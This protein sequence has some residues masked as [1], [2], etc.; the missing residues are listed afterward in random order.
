MPR[1]ARLFEGDL[2]QQLLA[3]V[4]REGGL[5]REQLVE[6]D[7]E[8][9]D[10][11]AVVD[12]DALG[13]RLLGAHVAERAQEVAGHRHAG[14]GF[15][16][17]EAEVGDPE[18]AALPS[19][20]EQVGRLDVAVEDAVLVGVVEGFGGLDAELGDGAE[21]FVG[22]SKSGSVRGW[23]WT[24]AVGACA[25]LLDAVSAV[26]PASRAGLAACRI[27]GVP[28]C[29]SARGT[30]LLDHFRQALAFDE[31]HRVV[32]DAA[33]AADRV[34]RDDVRV[35]ERGGGAGFVLEAGQLL[36]VEH[37]GERQHL[38]RDAAAEGELLGFVDDAHA[39]AADFAQDAKVAQRCPLRQG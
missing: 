24:G 23:R 4:A 27:N 28:N 6:R 20:Y 16:A 21:I 19:I 5:E 38:Q 25:E 17:R 8:R 12:D 33:F 39:A 37:R 29:R 9:V 7:A 31:L 26:G 13:E 10:V 15:D 3:V 35:V 1:R 22:E 11:A 36:A 34:D 2:A 30:Y 32:V 18:L 14:V